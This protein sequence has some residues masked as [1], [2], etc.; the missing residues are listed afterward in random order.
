[1]PV[2]CDFIQIVGDTPVT[3]GDS[4]AVWEANFNTGGRYSSG[5]AFLIFNI[6]GLT[7]TN[8]NVNVK[9]NNKNI[10]QIARYGGLSNE[11]RNNIAGFW[12]TQMIAMNGSTLNDGKNE[13]QIEAV[14]FPGSDN[15]NKFDDFQLK[16]VMCFFHQ[17]A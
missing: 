3:I 10:G 12:Y 6:R 7:Y 17:S 15:A 9:I 4:Q 16:D 14:G 8:K 2:L 5:T 1:M 13:I 11:E